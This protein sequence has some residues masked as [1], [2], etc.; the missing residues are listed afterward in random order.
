VKNDRRRYT[1]SCGIARALDVVGERWALLIVRELLLGPRRFG[2]L[3]DGLPDPSPNVLTQ[4]LRDLEDDGILRKYLLDPPA[5]VAVY[6]LTD[7]GR[8]LEPVLLELGRWGSATPRTSGRE[9][10]PA[11]M[12]IALK[13]MFDETTDARV[14]YEL[15]IGN[16]SFGIRI[17]DH[18]VVISRGRPA[19]ADAVLTTDVTTLRMVV[20]L[21]TGVRAAEA[22]GALTIAGD[23]RVAAR[24]PKLFRTPAG[25]AASSSRR[26]AATPLA[27]R[28]RAGTR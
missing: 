14:T 4:R 8:A 2:Q 18:R 15:R 17:A 22:A 12:L 1:D 26:A 10:S 11:S 6:E 3:R 13:A 27:P 9:L 19:Q 5:S 21:G 28:A 25:S 23:R 7:R 16:E 24:F 20:F